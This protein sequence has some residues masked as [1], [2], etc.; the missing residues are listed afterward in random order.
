M[1]PASDHIPCEYLVAE[2]LHGERQLPRLCPALD[3]WQAA[4]IASRLAAAKHRPTVKVFALT[5]GV[6]RLVLTL[7]L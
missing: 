4:R 3:P 5:A 1:V 7:R 6:S 2:Y